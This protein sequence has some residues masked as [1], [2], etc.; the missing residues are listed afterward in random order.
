MAN[1]RNLKT[2]I[3]V[4]S[5]ALLAEAVALHHYGPKVSDENINALIRSILTLRKDYVARVSHPEP[6]MTAKHYYNSLVQTFDKE[7][8][9]LLDQLSNVH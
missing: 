1:K 9:A 6:G 7:A 3:K 4:V 5:D 8:Q 2:V